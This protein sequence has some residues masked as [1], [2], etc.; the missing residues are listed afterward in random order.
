MVSPQVPPRI[1]KKYLQGEVRLKEYLAEVLESSQSWSEEKK[2]YFQSNHKER[3]KRVERMII[4]K[5][6]LFKE[7]KNGSQKPANIKECIKYTRK[8]NRGMD[9]EEIMY[10]VM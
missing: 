3:F 1:P 2:I 10:E 8:N 6:G 9:E 5:D 7:L 4:T